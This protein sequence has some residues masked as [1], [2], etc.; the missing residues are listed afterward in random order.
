MI[1]I[2][3]TLSILVSA[4]PAS[5]SV[6]TAEEQKAAAAITAPL[7]SA[8][9]EFLAS[10][11]LEGRGPAT[12]G[13]RL[14]LEYVATEL[15]SMGYQPAAPEGGWIQKVPLVSITPKTPDPMVFVSAGKK[16]SN[17]DP[18]RR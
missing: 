9:I 6:V 3:L 11:L 15:A 1:N 18:P 13:D 8:H 10:D 5:S 7:L 4:V 14:A 2:G 16:G 12:R 17:S